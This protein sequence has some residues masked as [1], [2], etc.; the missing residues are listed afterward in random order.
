MPESNEHDDDL[1]ERLGAS[2]RDESTGRDDEMEALLTPPR[3]KARDVLLDGFEDR[4][5]AG[6][7]KQPTPAVGGRDADLVQ[8]GPKRSGW[9]PVGISIGV[10]IAAAMLLWLLIPSEE[11]GGVAT[12]YTVASLQAGRAENRAVEVDL[13][14]TIVTAPND[15]FRAVLSPASAAAGPVSLAVV[16]RRPGQ[17]GICAHPTAGVEISDVGAVKLDGTLDQFAVVTPGQWQLEL[18]VG[19]RAS[20]PADGAASVGQAPDD[21]HVTAFAL[22]V[23][24]TP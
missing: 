2:V 13:T 22:E 21:V 18:W 9:L 3:G 8:L 5:Q 19:P 23:L 24:S 14:A 4:L 15:P 1:L 7:T 16:S 6:A 20:L 12:Q 17:N 11:G 10:A